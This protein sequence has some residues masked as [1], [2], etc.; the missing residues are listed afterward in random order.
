MVYAIERRGLLSHYMD[1]KHVTI[2]RDVALNRYPVEINVL[3]RV[4]APL[5]RDIE[6]RGIFF[7]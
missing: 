6:L 4:V 5:K 2:L 3:L 1:M 7:L